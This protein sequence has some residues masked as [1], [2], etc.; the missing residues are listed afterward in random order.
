MAFFGNSNQISTI[1][2]P[3]LLPGM[4]FANSKGITT[5]VPM[6]SQSETGTSAF[7]SSITGSNVYVN[8]QL[9][10]PTATT[11]APS[12][13]NLFFCSTDQRLYFYDG[14]TGYIGYKSS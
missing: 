7:F 6:I 8:S 1:E 2:G 11:G 10:I 4:L 3:V 13:G 9:N 14:S 12:Q 5:S